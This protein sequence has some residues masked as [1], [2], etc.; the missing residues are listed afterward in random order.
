LEAKKAGVKI[1]HFPWRSKASWAEKENGAGELTRRLVT[2]LEPT[3]A[4]SEA[5]RTLR[6]N[7]LY[8]VVDNP[9]KVIVLTSPGPGEGKS[10]T[11]ANLGVVLAQAAKSVLILDCD[12]RKPVIH[13]FFELRNLH[14]MM[15]IM[16]GERNLQ[17]VW[18]E[19][20]E[21]LKVV[22][23]GPIPPNPSE[24][25]GS[26]RFLRFLDGVRNEFDYVLIDASPVGLVS[27]PAILAT[28]GDAVLLVLDA[29]TTRKGALRESVRSLQA[30][31]ANILGIVMNNVDVPRGQYYYYGEANTYQG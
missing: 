23:V 22:P 11:C 15:N 27:D 16:M 3:S 4:A 30:V 17:E 21:G 9:P 13:E 26:R 7:L 29:E 5:Y 24:V 31:G 14:G 19:P 20:L 8:A 12:F 28:Q 18:Q 25:L 10:T 1:R 2:I 6:T